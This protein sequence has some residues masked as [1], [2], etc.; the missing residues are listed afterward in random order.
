MK[1][2]VT[3]ATGVLGRPVSRMLVDT[4]HTVRALARSSSNEVRMREIGAEPV[5]G[6]LFDPSSLRDVIGD[7]EAILHLATHIPRSSQARRRSA[8]R[9]N[10]RIRIEGTRNLVDIALQS[11]VSTFVYP[12]VVFAY[13]DRGDLWLNTAVTPER[14]PLLESSLQAEAEVQRFTK[15]GKRGIVLRM[16]G[17]YGSTAENTRI[18]LRAARYGFAMLFGPAKAYLPLIWIEDAALAVI[19]AL[20]KA[21]AEIYDIVDDEPL[22]RRELAAILADAVGRKHLFRP[23]TFLLRILAGKNSLFLARSQRVSNKRFKDATGWSPTVY[24]ARLGLKLLAIE[25]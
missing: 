3:G 8:W 16:G 18:M 13:P 22:Q 11:N 17:F 7:S 12:G 23:P 15:A 9:E 10:D 21:P 25:P 5:R 2:F 14:L 19:D 20:F 6:N 1:V 4:G 24:S